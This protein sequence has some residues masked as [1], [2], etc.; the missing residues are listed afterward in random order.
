MGPDFVPNEAVNIH[1]S[2]P[3]VVTSNANQNSLLEGD[4]PVQGREEVGGSLRNDDHVHD[5][6]GDGGGGGVKDDIHPS[7]TDRSSD[8]SSDDSLQDNIAQATTSNVPPAGVDISLN[9]GSDADHLSTAEDDSGSPV[10]TASAT[11]SI[12]DAQSSMVTAAGDNQHPLTLDTTEMGVE[13]QPS[14]NEHVHDT[15]ISQENQSEIQKGTSPSLLPQSQPASHGGD[16]SVSTQN[17]T[18]VSETSHGDDNS[19][20]PIVPSDGSMESNSGPGIGKDNPMNIGSNFSDV[21]SPL[22]GN[23]TLRNQTDPIDSELVVENGN[24][25]AN[26]S[27]SGSSTDKNENETVKQSSSPVVQNSTQNQN[28]TRNRTSNGL[29][30]GSRLKGLS[31]LPSQQKERS[32]FL[33]LSNHIEDLET[34]MTLF[35]IF[36]DQIS[37]R[38]VL[39]HVLL[40]S[41]QY[42]PPLLPNNSHV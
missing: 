2:T 1:T 25:T 30:S 9:S 15:S 32:V 40:S 22:N 24:L 5:T 3:G 19:S 38:Y 16:D 13:P 34:N 27:C 29:H 37:S 21:D 7:I 20:V 42:P 23:S 18:P 4:E 10:P 11:P 36:L 39:V 31:P 41:S 33:R 35:S 8:V 12:V 14:V 6:E 17:G 26:M 28:H